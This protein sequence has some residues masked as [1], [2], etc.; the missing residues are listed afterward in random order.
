MSG[1]N[2]SLF[3]TSVYD[4]CHLTEQN[5]CSQKAKLKENWC[6]NRNCY[7]KSAKKSITK[8]NGVEKKRL[9]THNESWK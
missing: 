3:F 9:L 8:P 1:Q 7:A 2:S 5:L 6:Q 4:C